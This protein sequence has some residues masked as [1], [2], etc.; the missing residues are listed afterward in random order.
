MHS[1]ASAR[2]CR[3]CSRYST[4]SAWALVLMAMQVCV[5]AISFTMMR[6][7]QPSRRAGAGVG[8][9]FPANFPPPRPPRGH[10]PSPSRVPD[11]PC[12]AATPLSFF[13]TSHIF[14][15]IE[16]RLFLRTL[17]IMGDSVI[18]K[19][20]SMAGISSLFLI[21]A[22]QRPARFH[23]AHQVRRDRSLDRRPALIH[24]I[25]AANGHAMLDRVPRSWCIG[26]AAILRRP[27]CT[28]AV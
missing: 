21:V 1:D 6:A 17:R 18:S 11:H 27:D 2:L 12:S 23:S 14:Q 9:K 10:L 26:V 22:S 24:P 19:S 7:A 8:A 15:S 4:D 13:S 5:T 25:G 20:A 16:Q 3:A 28:G